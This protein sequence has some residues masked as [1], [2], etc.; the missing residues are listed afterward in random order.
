ME[1][2]LLVSTD[3]PHSEV[4]RENGV[5]GDIVVTSLIRSL[6]PVVRYPT[7][8]RAEWVDYQAGIFRLLGR[9]GTSIRLGPVSLDMQD[10]RRIS[11][12]AV[13]PVAVLGV[14]AVLTREAGKDC[15]Q[16]S[17]AAN[18]EECTGGLNLTDEGA[19]DQLCRRVLERLWEERPMLPQHIAMGLI[20]SVR[21]RLVKFEEL[22]VNVRSGKLMGVVDLR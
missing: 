22:E 20:G 2:E 12:E 7:G 15:L 9:S 11:V 18:H 14:Q 4:I 6:T 19:R 13:S 5:A 3:E 8:D 17:I 21:V 1:L 16:V 10:V